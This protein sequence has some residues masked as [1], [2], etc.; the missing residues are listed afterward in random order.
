MNAGA[1]IISLLW[2]A[3]ASASC[4]A[5]VIPSPP[6]A[7]PDGVRFVFIDAAATRVAVAGSFNQW[8]SSTH[9]LIRDAGRPRWTATVRLPPGEYQFMFVVDGT[10]ITPPSAEDY[11]DDGFGTRNGIFVVPS[12]ER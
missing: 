3:I 8:S 11:A 6:V 12:E 4:A 9:P 10:W 2:I 7:T 1:G 5:R